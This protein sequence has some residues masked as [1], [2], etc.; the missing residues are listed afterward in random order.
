MREPLS[1]GQAGTPNHTRAAVARPV[2]AMHPKTAMREVE[3]Y[4]YRSGAEC[5]DL[6]VSDI[7]RS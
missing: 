1:D 3:M 4:W 5:L 6:A 7:D 2:A